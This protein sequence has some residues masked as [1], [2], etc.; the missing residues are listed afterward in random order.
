M[1]KPLQRQQGIRILCCQ[2]AVVG[3]WLM[4]VFMQQ[5]HQSAMPGT[6]F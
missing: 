4:L 5:L 3:V 1:R 2:Q 6:F